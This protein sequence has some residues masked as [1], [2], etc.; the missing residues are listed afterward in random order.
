MEYY[1]SIE[2][3]DKRNTEDRQVT[4]QSN[5]WY[6]N[7]LVI[8]NPYYKKT[9]EETNEDK[10]SGVNKVYCDIDKCYYRIPS[11]WKLQSN[12]TYSSLVNERGWPEN[13][14]DYRV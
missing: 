4:I 5:N 1:N 9:E 11:N 10:P 14:N 7:D 8:N 12:W 13:K 6:D 3:I 2:E